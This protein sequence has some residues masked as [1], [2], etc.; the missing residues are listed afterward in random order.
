MAETGSAFFQLRFSTFT[1]TGSTMKCPKCNYT[2]FDYLTECK[3][4]GQLLDEVRR[5]LNLQ[6]SKPILK[7]EEAAAPEVENQVEDA[8]LEKQEGEADG[9]QENT[10][11]DDNGHQEEEELIAVSSAMD[12]AAPPLEGLGSMENL[13]ETGLHHDFPDEMPPA[14]E[15]PEMAAVFNPSDD[16]LENLHIEVESVVEDE[17]LPELDA[18]ISD[19]Q[20]SDA[21]EDE[22][23][24]H[25]KVIE[26]S[27]EDQIFDL[28]LDLE[29]KQETTT[30]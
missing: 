28:E 25:G 2:S 11:A 4:C 10:S 6:V 22:D 16:Q 27:E 9:G 30:G 1:L 18:E 26:L 17:E 13:L 14:E 24:D 7:V 19:E 5:K 23:Y 8:D 12:D 3:K 21:L 20:N 15:K 29:D